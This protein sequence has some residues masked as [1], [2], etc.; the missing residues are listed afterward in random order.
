MTL[1]VLRVPDWLPMRTITALVLT[2]RSDPGWAFT[3]EPVPSVQPAPRLG[4][5][6]PELLEGALL[7]EAPSLS[8]ALGSGS[9]GAHSSGRRAPA[10]TSSSAGTWSDYR[11]TRSTSF[12]GREGWHEEGQPSQSTLGGGWQW[13]GGQGTGGCLG[14]LGPTGDPRDHQR[15]SKCI[16]VV[17][18]SHRPSRTRA[19]RSPSRGPYEGLR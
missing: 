19:G 15:C 12:H 18:Q 6:V 1:I 9:P 14:P 16:P 11:A 8:V 4:L 7:V 17:G 3:K 10:G 13:A 2:G 5:Q